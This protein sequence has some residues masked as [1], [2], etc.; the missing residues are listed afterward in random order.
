MPPFLFD[1]LSYE[2]ERKMVL[3]G[4]GN[5]YEIGKWNYRQQSTKQI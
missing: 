4:M 3:R 5:S 1:A 2:R